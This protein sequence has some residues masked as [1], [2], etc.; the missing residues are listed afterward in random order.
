MRKAIIFI[1]ITAVIFTVSCK[2]DRLSDKELTSKGRIITLSAVMPEDELQT[3]IA[4]TKVDRNVN[5]TWED[6]DQLQLCFVQGA[7]KIKQTVTVKNISTDRKKAGFD[8]VVPGEITTGNFDL[9]GVYGGGGLSESNPIMAVLPSNPENAVS[10]AGVKTRKDVMLKFAKTSIAVS[11]PVISVTFQHMG[12]LFCVSV[13][14]TGST[15]LE[16]IKQARIKATTNGWANNTGAGAGQYDLVNNT[17]SAETISGNY[18]SFNAAASTLAAG[19]TMSFWAWYPSVPSALWPQ[20]KLE[21]IKTDDS[22]LAVS[23]T[24]KPERTEAT[25]AGKSFYFYATWDGSQLEFADAAFTPVPSIEDL[26]ITGDLLHAENGSNFIGVIYSKSGTLYYNEAQADGTWSGEVSLGTG[27]EARLAIDGADHPHVVYK[28]ADNKIAY[29]KHNGTAWS[30]AS[31]IES[32]N[33]GGAGGCSIPDIAID[34]DGFAHITYTDSRG[35]YDLYN[36]QDIMYAVNSSGTFIKTGMY[37]G[38]YE[39]LGGST[40]Q[41]NYYDKGSRIAV[42]GT[43]RYFIMTHSAY[44]YRWTVPADWTYS[45]QIKSNAATGASAG[46][47]SDKCGLYDLEF[48]GTDIKALYKDNNINCTSTLSISGATISITGIQNLE[49]TITP[50]TLSA[51]ASSTVIGGTAGS[52]PFTKYNSVELVYTGISTKTGTIVAT[53]HIDG[54]FYALY[55]DNSDGKVKIK[56]VATS[57]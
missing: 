57:L 55:T 38:Y 41:G 20:L 22:S 31:Y 27:S 18:L 44:Y 10:L 47:P 1:F 9:Y 56:R 25:A 42:D 37:N 39:N 30:S 24:S 5:L 49:T 28:T 43:G 6:G 33:I 12:S 29:Q 53:A 2:D 17:F 35:I 54:L 8:I 7:T 40:Y 14:N 19:E 50:Y 34:A 15:S 48:N 36:K 26:S 52:Q 11:N 23:V 13:K 46:Y 51:N 3:R 4:L 21:L 16:S 45:I 32:N